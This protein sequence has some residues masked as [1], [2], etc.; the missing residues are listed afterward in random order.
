M[1][2]E[3]SSNVGFQFSLGGGEGSGP[4]ISRLRDRCFSFP[5]AVRGAWARRAR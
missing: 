3:L 4:G 1:G 5:V 2:S